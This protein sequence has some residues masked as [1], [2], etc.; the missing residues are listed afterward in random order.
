MKQVYV[1]GGG[2]AGMMAAISAKMHHPEM[3]VTIL[4]GN[5][6]LGKKLRLSGGG[7]CNVT[8]AL[9]HEDLVKG[10]VKNGKFLYSALQQFDAQAIQAFFEALHCPL[11]VE[12]HQRVFPC[13]DDANDI[14]L[15]L[16]N[17]LATLGVRI[18]Y[19]AKVDA[20]DAQQCIIYAGNQKFMYDAIILATG[21]KTYAET[22]SDG[23]G[24]ELAQRMGHTITALK[25]AEVPLVSNDQVIQDKQLQGLSF[26]DVELCVYQKGKVKQRI[27]HDLLFTHFGLSGPAALRASYYVLQVLDKSD[28]VDLTIDFLPDY[29]QPELL[30]DIMQADPKEALMKLGLPKRLLEYVVAIS[31]DKLSL[32]NNLKKYPISIYTTRGFANAFVTNGGVKI[33]EIDPKTMKSKLNPHIS[34]AGELMDMSAFT[35]GYNISVAFISGYVA[36]K[37][38]DL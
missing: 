28:I 19:E 13:S 36:G 38:V 14:V 10:I 21:G 7:R 8:A 15:A 2:P 9:S 3:A 11:K 26:H 16:K 4:E 33:K 30:A 5:L 34:F 17:Q 27:R 18:V 25:P 29:K 1:V 22:G 6:K 32:I 31:K 12:D 20:I 24:Y 23:T 35:G 37:Y